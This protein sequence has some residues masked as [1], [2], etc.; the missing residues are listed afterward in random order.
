MST[1]DAVNIFVLWTRSLVPNREALE[2]VNI[3]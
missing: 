1:R 2:Q 3:G